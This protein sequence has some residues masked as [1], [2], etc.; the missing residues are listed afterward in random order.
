VLNVKSMYVSM[1]LHRI[2]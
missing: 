2:N 1:V